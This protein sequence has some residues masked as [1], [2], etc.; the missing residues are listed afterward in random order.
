MGSEMCIR[1]SSGA[2]PRPL[3]AAWPN[4]SNTARMGWHGCRR[5]RAAA[6]GCALSCAPGVSTQHARA[7]RR[8]ACPWR[9]RAQEQPG[10]ARPTAQIRHRLSLTG[11]RGAQCSCAAAARRRRQRHARATGIERCRSNVRHLADTRAQPHVHTQR[12]ET[13]PCTEARMP[14]V[15]R[16]SGPARTH[17]SRRATEHTGHTRDRA[18]STPSITIRIRRKIA[19][20]KSLRGCSRK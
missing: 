17:S 2:S 9:R 19:R 4:T 7:R 10:R 16:G 13:P 18:A 1:D 8:S 6:A 15:I 12:W 14:M 3:P 5:E 20:M 11:T